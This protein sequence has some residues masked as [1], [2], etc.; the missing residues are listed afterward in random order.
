MLFKIP[1]MYNTRW[2]NVFVV[3]MAM[4]TVIFTS[5]SAYTRCTVN[6][7]YNNKNFVDFIDLEKSKFNGPDYML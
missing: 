1:I 2:N 5:E 7:T 3:S 6:H 4:M